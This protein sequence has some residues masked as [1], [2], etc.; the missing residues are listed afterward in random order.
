VRR[1]DHD[2]IGLRLGERHPQL[3]RA[4][5]LAVVEAGVGQL[6]ERPAQ[7]AAPRQAREEREVGGA[8]EGKVCALPD[9]GA[10]TEVAA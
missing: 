3:G 7:G 8:G 2:R 6:G 1:G 10:A 5:Q 4:A 9:P